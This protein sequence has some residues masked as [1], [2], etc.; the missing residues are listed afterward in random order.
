[1]IP[2]VQIGDGDDNADWLKVIAD[3][4][5]QEEDIAAS[6]A[7]VEDEEDEEDTDA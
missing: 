2:K 7:L 4:K 6:E 3:G 5:Y 1:M